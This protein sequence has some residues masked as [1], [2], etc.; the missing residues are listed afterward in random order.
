MAKEL[1]PPP[2]PTWFDTATLVFSII[3]ALLA[4]GAVIMAGLF[5]RGNRTI[6]ALISHLQPPL[7]YGDINI[8]T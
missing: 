7:S 4:L 2:A 5:I 6:R 8:G 1:K 3:E